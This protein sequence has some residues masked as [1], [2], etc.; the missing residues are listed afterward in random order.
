MTRVPS[1]E[2]PAEPR[3]AWPIRMVALERGNEDDLSDSTSVVERLAMMWP[4]ATEAW[5]LMGQPV[6]E[7][8][9]AH[10][11]VRIVRVAGPDETR[12]R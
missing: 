9:R 11:P 3:T 10:T 12:S 1:S 8:D 6:P 5:A 2:S 4:L 7:Y